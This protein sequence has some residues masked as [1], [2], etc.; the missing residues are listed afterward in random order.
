MTPDSNPGNPASATVGSS[1]I[2]AERFAPVTATPRS[3]PDFAC[4]I[5]EG[6]LAK[7]T[8]I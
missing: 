6:M 1:G 4:A 8:W 5:A 3:L 2:A 7:L